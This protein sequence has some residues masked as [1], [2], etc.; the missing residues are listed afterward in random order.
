MKVNLV[1]LVPR[2]S[3]QR[4]HDPIEDFRFTQ[5]FLQIES[6]FKRLTD[7]VNDRLSKVSAPMANSR[8][9]GKISRA[10]M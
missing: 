6:V 1:F 8:S 2:S 10:S 9:S 4:V 7:R 5:N 3:E